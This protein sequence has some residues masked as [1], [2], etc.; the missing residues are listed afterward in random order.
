[1]GNATACSGAVN[2]QSSIGNCQLP[3]SAAFLRITVM[4][5][6]IHQLQKLGAP[7]VAVVGDF[8]LDCYVYGDADRISPEAPVP[9]LRVIRREQRTGGASNVAA[10]VTAL[11]GKALCFG[12]AGQDEAGGQLDAL[13]RG[14]G[15]DT[16]GIVRIPGR[17][18]TVKSRYVGL[19][20]HRHQ[21][22]I[23]RVDDEVTQAIAPATAAALQKAFTAALADCDV[24]A[25]E[26][27]GK[28][29]LTAA[30]APQLIAAAKAAGKKVLVDPALTDDYSPYVGATL[31]TPNR[32]EAQVASGI[33]ITNDASLAAAAARII[34]IAQA[35]AVLIKL[36]REGAYLH[37]RDGQGRR[38]A[39]RPRQVYDVTGAGDEVLAMLAVALAGGIEYA[40][41]AAL[42]NVAGGLEVERF[43]VVPIR[44]EEVVE[45]LRRSLGLR[46]GKVLSRPELAD[47]IAR[48]QGR[49]ETVVFTNGCFDLLH[50]G[51]VRYLRQARELGSCLVVAINSDASV[52]RLKGPT[53]PVIGEEER[54]EMLAALECVDFVTVFDED[55]PEAL[56]QLLRPQLLV[57]GGSTPYVV[58]RDIVEGYGGHVLTLDLVQ[59]LS[60]TQIINRIVSTTANP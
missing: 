33:E 50:M 22:Q 1:M 2:R 60:T 6:L 42:A 54:A 43:G 31:L 28:G 17:S 40:D 35:E 4:Q 58:G 44:R 16:A 8:M 49:G 51:H 45:E 29:V 37:T 41:A 20:R 36:D 48:R 18:T 11:G 39:T 23:L 5:D 32:Y 7:R 19:A 47:E 57:K 38:I 56:L 10:A 26:D 30:N 12:V 52:Q 55:T 3:P 27:Y 34:E 15:C 53:R 9:V 59:G 21:Q 46:G 24:I 13:L 25:L 14:C